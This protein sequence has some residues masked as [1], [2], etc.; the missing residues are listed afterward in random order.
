MGEI[1]K[2]S[3]RKNISVNTLDKVREFLKKQDGPVFKSYISEKA[4]VDYN[5]LKVALGMLNIYTTKDGR[6]RLK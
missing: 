4:G 2:N 5:S 3:E 1:K 6:V